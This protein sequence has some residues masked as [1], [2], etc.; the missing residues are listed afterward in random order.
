MLRK[1]LTWDCFFHSLIGCILTIL[2]G[3]IFNVNLSLI[4]SILITIV[5]FGREGL[6]A[7]YN[8]SY[9]WPWQWSNHKLAEAFSWPIGIIIGLTITIIVE[10]LNDLK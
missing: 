7:F 10:V 4:G 1:F 3:M 9:I 2:I 8:N 5:G 6:Q